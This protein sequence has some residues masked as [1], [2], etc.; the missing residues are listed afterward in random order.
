MKVIG[1]TGGIGAGKSTVV[2]LA[3]REFPVAVIFTDL[4]AREQMRKGGCSYQEVVQEF[5][6]EILLEDGEINRNKLAEIIFS[7]ADK[8]K[9]INAITHPNVINYVK[10]KIEEYRRSGK[11]RAVLVE[12]ALLFE[13]KMDKI[14]D[15]TWCIYADQ[16]VRRERLVQS[17][18][19]SNEKIDAIFEKQ[20]KDEY[21]REHCTYEIVN[22]NETT[23][24][25]LVETIRIRL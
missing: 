16:E 13:A 17:R 4:V 23:E 2:N 7:D 15:E 18:N 3:K 22:N 19:Y 25:E 20:D 12:T 14:C 21:A 8:V 5:G 1:V 10:E 24:S 6:E 9:K 11:Y